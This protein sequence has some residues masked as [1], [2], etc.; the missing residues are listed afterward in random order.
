MS[1]AGRGQTRLI[2]LPEDVEGRLASSLSV[3][4]VNVIE[5]IEN[6]PDSRVLEEYVRSNVPVIDISWLQAGP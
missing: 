5:L 2:L 3:P 4:R 1:I 6:A